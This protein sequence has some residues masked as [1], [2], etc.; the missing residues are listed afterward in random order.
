MIPVAGVSLLTATVLTL[1]VS[2]GAPASL[3]WGTGLA[4]ALYILS[5]W[6]RMRRAARFYIL[7]AIA[8]SALAAAVGKLDPEALRRA[9]AAMGFV[10]T[11]FVSFGVL[12]EAALTSPLVRRCGRFLAH[13]PPG[14]RYLALTLGGHLFGMILNFGVIPLLGTMVTEGTRAADHPEEDAD[15]A[16]RATVRRLRMTQAIHRGFA[17]T[18]TWSPLTVSLAVILTAL[19]SLSWSAA[20]PAMLGAATGFV[21]IGWVMDRFSRARLRVAPPPASP[22]EDQG[23]WALVLPVLA[24][25][26]AILGVGWLMEE[27]LGIRLVIG[28]MLFVPLLAAAWIVLQDSAVLGF[29]LA[30]SDTATRL[31]HYVRDTL[32]AYN[33]ELAIVG[34]AS[35]IG[36]VVT[37]LLHADA[38]PGLLAGIG[39][40]SWALMAIVPWLAIAFGQIGMS[41]VLAISLLAAAIPSPESLGLPAPVMAVTYSGSWALMAASS[42]FTAAVALSARVATAPGRPVGAAAFGARDNGGFTVVCALAL[43]LYVIA[44]TRLMA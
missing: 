36:G 6:G 19:P 1:A 44:L 10:A 18:L 40:P 39:L 16:R 24:L 32:P 15:Q 23:S 17:A 5:V 38:V 25:V 8:A 29:G 13:R 28:V 11:L 21:A 31:G 33:G 12:R 7:A 26:A 20:A 2:L 30:L 37:G 35:F 3:T 41:P 34:S 4:L 42:P 9:I 43:S 22:E 14:W 27:V